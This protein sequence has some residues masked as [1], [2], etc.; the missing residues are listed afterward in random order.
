MGRGQWSD[1]SVSPQPL[2]IA[3]G[4][5]ESHILNPDQRE[6]M[7][8]GIGLPQLHGLKFK[9]NKPTKKTALFKLSWQQFFL[10]G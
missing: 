3:S 4:R 5:Q 7:K 8:K 2:E 1:F 9:T 10:I 6:T